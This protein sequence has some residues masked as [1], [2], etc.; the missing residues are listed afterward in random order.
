[1]KN[2][3]AFAL[4]T[5]YVDSEILGINEPERVQFRLTKVCS[6]LVVNETYIDTRKDDEK[7]SLEITYRY[8][9]PLNSNHNSAFREEYPRDWGTG[10]AGYD[11]Q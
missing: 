10:G 9:Y 6:P 3:S 5:G 11:V 2:S 1:L 4:D 7:G 8:E